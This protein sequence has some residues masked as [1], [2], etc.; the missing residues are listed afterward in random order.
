MLFTRN[1]GNIVMDT[2]DVEM[3]TLNALGGTDM[4]TVNDMSGTDL[5]ELSTDLAGTLGS[6]VGDGAQDVVIV[7]ASNGDDIATVFGS[8]SESRVSGLATTVRM[9]SSEPAN[10]RLTVNGLA[11]DDVID[12]SRLPAGVTPLTVDGGTGDD[13]A[14]GG[15]GDDTLLGNDGDDVLI[16]GPGTDVLDG[17]AGEDTLIEGEVVSNGQVAGQRWLDA[18]ARSVADKTVLD[19]GGESVTLPAR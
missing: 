8:A 15:E 6:G 10:D 12:A 17:G 4:L 1:L 18:H 2:D 16:G 14:I 13:V 3:I 19:L 7:N 11:G 9:T 5:T